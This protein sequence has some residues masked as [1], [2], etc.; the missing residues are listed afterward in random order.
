MTWWLMASAP[1]KR[2]VIREATAFCHRRQ[3]LIAPN[4]CAFKRLGGRGTKNLLMTLETSIW[5]KYQLT[6]LSARLSL[7]LKVLTKMLSICMFSPRQKLFAKS[8]K[9]TPKITDTVSDLKTRCSLLLLKLSSVMLGSSE[10]CQSKTNLNV[11]TWLG[12]RT[13]LSLGVQPW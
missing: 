4:T 9:R 13:I 5:P 3:R 1:C 10:I 6:W 2:P 11:S 12:K 8:W 7:S